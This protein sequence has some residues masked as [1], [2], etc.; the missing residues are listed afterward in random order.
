[1]KLFF[2][3]AFHSVKN[4]IRKLFKSW[5]LIF[6]VVCLVIGGLMGYG[7]S[8][9]EELG[10]DPGQVEVTPDEAGETVEIEIPGVFP[11]PET[12]GGFGL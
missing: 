11:D 7:A 1:M 4:Q 5:V 2:Y 6:L 8:K 3:Y 10:D 12:P 9:L